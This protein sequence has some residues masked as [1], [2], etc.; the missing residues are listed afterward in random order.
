MLPDNFD[1]AQLP[2]DQK[3]FTLKEVGIG[4]STIEDID[5]R[6]LSYLKDDLK[7]STFTVDG[8]VQIP[9]IWVAAERSFQI[10][11]DQTLRDETGTLKLPLISLER[12]GI[13]KDPTKKG[14]FQAHYYSDEKD[15]RIGRIVIAKRIV[16]QKTRDNAVAQSKNIYTGGT[17]QENFPRVNKQVI[18]ESLSIPF[19]VYI[20]LD[21]K[22]TI[23]ADYQTQMNDLITPFITRTGQINSLVLR[24]N[25]HI[26]EVFIDQSFS[27]TNNGASLGEDERTFST[28]I[29]LR[30]LGYLIGEPNNEERP[31]I[32]REQ[33][34]VK[35]YYPSES[36]VSKGNDKFI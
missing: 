1:F 30:V 32:K 7:L 12:T 20:N 21:Y 28:E 33:N 31:V 15:G 4:T 26:Y 14:G 11:N 6:V 23:K 22:I 13:T 17:Q 18:V 10:K 2:K 27:P 24:N 35:L 8:L 36:V 3:E 5:K 34:V 25:G 29:K 19:P 9:V 16:Q